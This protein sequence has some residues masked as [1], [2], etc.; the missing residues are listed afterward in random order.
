MLVSWLN[1]TTLP[2]SPSNMPPT[3]C[4]TACW[5]W[6]SHVHAAARGRVRRLVFPRRLAVQGK[7]A[8]DW[9][10]RKACSGKTLLMPYL[11][12]EWSLTM[13]KSCTRRPA[14]LSVSNVEA[15]KA[16]SIWSQSV[17]WTSKMGRGCGLLRRSG[18]GLLLED[19]GGYSSSCVTWQGQASQASVTQRGWLY[20]VLSCYRR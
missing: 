14:P 5:P 10:T 15:K 1:N 12:A 8:S 7:K 9:G 2:V 19:P 13:Q 6:I 4:I 16:M 18:F 11:V 3:S 20:V 17:A